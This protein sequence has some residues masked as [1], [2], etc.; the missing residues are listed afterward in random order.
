MPKTTGMLM[1]LSG[2]PYV[3]VRLANSR[4]YF[5]IRGCP[6]AADVDARVAAVAEI[7]VDLRQARKETVVEEFARRAAEARTASEL[8]GVRMAVRA[9]HEG[10]V[11]ARPRFDDTITF[12]QFAEKWYTGALHEAYPRQI[13]VKKTSDQDKQFLTKWVF[14]YIGDTPLLAV[15]IDHCEDVL[16]AIPEDKSDHVARHVAQVM[17]RVFTLARYPVKLIKASPIPPGFVPKIRSKKARTYLYADEDRLLLGCTDIYL[18][19]RLLYGMLDREG[20]RI[21]EALS[22]DFVDLDLKNGIIHLDKNKTDD[23]RP[24]ALD[25]SVAEALRLWKKHFHPKP[26]PQSRVFV[27]PSESREVGQPL[28]SATRA[29][30]LRANV[31]KA[32]CRRPQLFER[33]EE[34]RPLCIHDL[35]ATFVT[36]SLA[37]GRTE[38]WVAN[39]TGHKSSKMINEYRRQAECHRELLMGGLAPLVEAIPELAA[40]RANLEKGADAAAE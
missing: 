2:Q 9:I 28:A 22:L 37:N 36:I 15:T 3:R 19:L 1:W 34:R 39:R 21:D 14:P 38:S 40:V 29:E 10:E 24:W 4:P 11:T 16:N 5:R 31:R 12:K 20:L 25:P 7:I 33:S 27:Y 26:A 13:K 18:V 32:G 30:E 35:R 8:E 23:P 6:T 17:R